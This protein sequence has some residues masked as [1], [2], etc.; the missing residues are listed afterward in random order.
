MLCC[1][2]LVQFVFTCKKKLFMLYIKNILSCLFINLLIFPFFVP[3]LLSSIWQGVSYVVQLQPTF[4]NLIINCNVIR[5]ETQI[6]EPE[7]FYSLCKENWFTSFHTITQFWPFFHLFVCACQGRD[8]EHETLKEDLHPNIVI[9]KY[10]NTNNLLKSQIPLYQDYKSNGISV[11]SNHP[12]PPNKILNVQ[13]VE[14]HCNPK[15]KNRS[16]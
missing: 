8:T 9:S 11:F 10:N 12:N 1:Q 7:N 2:V 6:Q 5:R 4:K 14:C 16:K 3:T 15:T 13:C